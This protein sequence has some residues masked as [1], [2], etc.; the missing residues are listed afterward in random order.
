MEESYRL[1]GFPYRTR[2]LFC[3]SRE[4]SPGGFLHACREIYNPGIRTTWTHYLR[5]KKHTLVQILATQ[6]FS[7][8]Q[9][10]VEMGTF[11]SRPLPLWKFA[12]SLQESCQ[13]AVKELGEKKKL[14]GDD[15]EE[16]EWYTDNLP[17][18]GL[19]RF[20][21]SDIL[22]SRH[23]QNSREQDSGVKFFKIRDKSREMCFIGSIDHEIAQRKMIQRTATLRL[24]QSPSAPG[25][26]LA[27]VDDHIIG[28]HV[29]HIT[30]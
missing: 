7:C 5:K 18:L 4:D 29:S 13:T 28:S 6:C 10:N 19:A 22:T 26:S 16:D 9:P 8:L 30:P 12:D 1:E 25:S 21:Q 3:L 17:P 24:P 23:F 15:R 11:A 14:V 27:S 2:I 20:F